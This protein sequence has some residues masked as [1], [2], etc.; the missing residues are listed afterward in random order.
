MGYCLQADLCGQTPTWIDHFAHSGDGN[1]GGRRGMGV[2]EEQITSA[3]EPYRAM[4]L[5]IARNVLPIP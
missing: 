5:P 3:N 4:Y 1:I 2:T